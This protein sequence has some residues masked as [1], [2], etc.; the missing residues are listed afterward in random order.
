MMKADNDLV[1]W[2]DERFHDILTVIMDTD[3][4]RRLEKLRIY[5]SAGSGS[6]D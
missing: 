5:V 1:T 6:V 2:H 3:I 4:A